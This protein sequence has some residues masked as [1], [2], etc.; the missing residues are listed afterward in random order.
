MG[1]Y[2]GSFSARKKAREEAREHL[3]SVAQKVRESNDE[4]EDMIRAQME[5]TRR[6]YDF[7]EMDFS[8]LLGMER[9]FY[10]RRII[11]GLPLNVQSLLTFCRTFG[12]DLSNLVNSAYLD[13]HDSVL[14]ETAVFLSG[15]PV[16]T[17]QKIKDAVQNSDDTDSRK[18][19]G[20]LLM[21]RLMD[22]AK[23]QNDALYLFGDDIPDKTKASKKSQK[24][25]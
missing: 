25:D 9:S 7:T 18:R 3:M 8:T 10:S 23:S 4:I 19:Q 17:I 22:F 15:L 16:E 24:H 1:N 21:S 11:R 12:Y 20:E 5:H 2:S 14:R 13:S 6:Y